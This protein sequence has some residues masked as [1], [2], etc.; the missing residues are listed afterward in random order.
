[1]VDALLFDFDGT[2][3]ETERH[4]HRVAYNAAFAELGLPWFWDEALYAQLVAIG[5]G[6]ERIIVYL[7]R[8]RPAGWQRDDRATL[9]EAIH[10]A[11]V[12][13]F[14]TLVASIELRPGVRRLA[15]EARAGGTRLAIVTAAGPASVAALLARD[16]E[17]RDAFEL[18]V[19]GSAVTRKKPAPDGYLHAVERLGADPRRCLA[20]EDSAIGLQAAR[21]AGITTL[22]TVSDFTR[23]DDFSGA[24]AVL[25][26]LGEP[27]APAATL[28]GM[29]PPA[30]FADLAYAR[31][32]IDAS[33]ATPAG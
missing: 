24:A 25:S 8:Y 26:D 23:D 14:G 18:V 7:D 20:I 6:R 16:P 21:A 2:I 13:I 22:V 15:R 29:P 4:G 30:G 33:R 32:L 3:A 5:G 1:V 9:I 11:K 12:R 17:L 10:A 19:A 31:S 28:A 27:A